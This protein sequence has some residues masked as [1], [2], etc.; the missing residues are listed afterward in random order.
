M[1]KKVYNN[2]ADHRVIDNDRVV[3][4]VTKIGLPETK[5]G[6]STISSAGMVMDVDM[7]NTT[8]LE[9]MEFTIYHNNGVNCGHLSDPGKHVIEVRLARQ[10]YDVGQAE[11]NHESVKYRITGVY[12]GTQEG[13]IETGSPIGSTEKYSVLRYEKEVNGE[14]EVLIDAMAG[15][16][17][18]NGVNYTDEIENLLK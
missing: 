15:I 9:A 14:V 3:E 4:D 17:Q 5:H 16:I 1:P 8:H 7:P 6:T 10:Q 18:H 13:D 11:I 12:K 2:V